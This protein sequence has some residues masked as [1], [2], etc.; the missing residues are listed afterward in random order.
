M[1]QLGL[2]FTQYNQ[3]YDEKF[4]GSYFYGQG[5]AEEI[6]PY[7]KSTQVYQC[8]DDP[9]SPG[10]NETAYYPNKL[11]YTANVHLLD[12]NKSSDQL[13]TAATL[14]QLVAPST[15]VLLY[16]GEAAWA[17]Y[18]GP[19]SPI[20]AEQQPTNWTRLYPTAAFP[21]LDNQSKVGDGSGDY[22]SVPV[23]VDR[24][25]ADNADAAGI[26]NSGRLNFLAADGH[27]KNMDASW[28]NKGGSVSV[29]DY[30]A[31]SN[32]YAAVG[33]DNLT[34]AQNGK[35]DYAMS[36]NPNPT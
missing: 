20:S 21:D 25:Q 32:A 15:T 36:F 28:D 10:A 7:V 22:Y 35:A 2:G 24:H 11:S 30:P 26:V 14:S 3:D 31:A 23:Q 12:I 13:A 34:K 9:R 18:S 5:W 17:G 4:T 33:Q 27:A 6:Y 8:P 1:K 19:G 16:E 29:G